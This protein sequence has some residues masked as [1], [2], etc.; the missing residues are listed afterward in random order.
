MMSWKRELRLA[1][2]V[3]LYALNREK[4]IDRKGKGA[5][6]LSSDS[7]NLELETRNPRKRRGENLKPYRL[8]TKKR[9]KVFL[10]AK[11]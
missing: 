10:L 1:G 3:Y 5:K 8:T 6:E 11:I 4:H 7:Q 2:N 9:A